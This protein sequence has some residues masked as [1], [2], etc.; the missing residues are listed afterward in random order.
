MLFSRRRKPA[1][2]PIEEF[3]V[4]WSEARSRVEA[5]IAAHE[6]SDGLV[7]DIAARVRAIHP[8]LEW[9][10]GKGSVAKHV[11]V[12]SGAGNSALR[13]VTERWRR[14]GPPADETFEFA[15]ARQADLSTMEAKLALDGHTVELGDLRFA[16]VLDDSRAQIDVRVWHPDFAELSP[17]TRLRVTFLSLSW[18][19]GEDGVEIWIGEITT[20]TERPADAGSG[21]ELATAVADLAAHHRE[22]RWALLQGT[23]RGAPLLAMIQVP[24]K[25]AR[26]PLLDTHLA[27]TVPYRLANDAGFPIESSL[28]A[29]RELEDRI[30]AYVD[31]AVIVAHETSARV[32]TFHLYADGAVPSEVIKPVVASWA[33]GRTEMR[34]TQDPDWEQ[35]SHLRP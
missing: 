3:W 30:N 16:Y 14:A 11:L 20:A 28:E 12:V 13:A 1:G 8:N 6:W 33:E 18:L 10:F 5:A 31:G 17:D 7:A 35:I 15:P 34:V 21:T 4:W 27:L 19:L 26:W 32:R 23:V 29:L 24:L 9:E 2:S 22:P 25:P